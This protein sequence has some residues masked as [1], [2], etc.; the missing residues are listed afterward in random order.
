MRLREGELV[1]LASA[2]VNALV[3]QGFVHAKRDSGVLRDRIREL[4]A[5]GTNFSL[6]PGT[7][8]REDREY[9]LG[10]EGG[11]SHRRILH[12]TDATGRA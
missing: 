2:I 9:D 6:R 12:A 4:I 8:D 5:L 7:E 3:K 1:A 11:H 10:R